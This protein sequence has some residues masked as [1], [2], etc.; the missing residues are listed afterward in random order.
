[1]IEVEENYVIEQLDKQDRI[2]FSC[3]VA[4]LDRYLH[5]QA[6]QDLKKSMSVTYVLTENGSNVI[7]GYYSLS[8]IGIFPGELPNDLIKKFPKYPRLPGVLL[9]RLAIDEKYKGNGLG[10]RLLVDA[11]RRSL[12]VSKQI[13][14][15]AVIVDAKNKAAMEFYKHFGFIA[16]IDNQF[17]LFIPLNSLKKL[18]LE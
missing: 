12:V 9:G 16:F 10:S 8:T 15:V 2:G 18:G 13:G 6:N 14:I 11:L 4:E 1:M 3:G 5:T 17:K 7:L